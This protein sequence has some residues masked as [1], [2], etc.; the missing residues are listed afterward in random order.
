M[1][2][3]VLLLAGAANDQERASSHAQR[4]R[5]VEGTGAG[6]GRQIAIGLM[7]HIAGGTFELWKFA[8]YTPEAE[9]IAEYVLHLNSWK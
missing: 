2:G 4:R 7:R 6:I 5:I 8:K 1:I 3:A 9:H